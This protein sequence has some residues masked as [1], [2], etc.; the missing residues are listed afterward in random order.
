MDMPLKSIAQFYGEPQVQSWQMAALDALNVL[1]MLVDGTGKALDANQAARAW[2]GQ[3]ATPLSAL[4]TDL[5]RQALLRA[6]WQAQGRGDQAP[7]MAAVHL[8]FDARHAGTLCVALPVGAQEHVFA[9]NSGAALLMICRSGPKAPAQTLL[10]QL[11]G[12]SATELQVAVALALGHTPQD[13]AE[14]RS[15]KES[16]VRSH[17]KAIFRKM[18]VRRL[19]DMTRVL[20]DLALV[21]A[22]V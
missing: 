18:H 22:H 1:V 17:I 7:R 12:L 16:T 9:A 8:Q 2:L 4:S 14:Q 5:D 3:A 20:T 19:R 21:D 15:V 10:Q 13:V 6:I 11:F